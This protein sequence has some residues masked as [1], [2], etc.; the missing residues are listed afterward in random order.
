MRKR[1]AKR[2]L[3]LY[4]SDSKGLTETFN[5]VENALAILGKDVPKIKCSSKVRRDVSSTM[6]CNGEILHGDRGNEK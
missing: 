4:N 6:K 3:G 5:L 2:K 1:E